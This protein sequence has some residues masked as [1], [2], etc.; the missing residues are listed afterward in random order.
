MASEHIE[1]IEDND[2]GLNSFVNNWLFKWICSGLNFDTNEE[3][4]KRKKKILQI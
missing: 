4:N 2:A 1:D 3:M